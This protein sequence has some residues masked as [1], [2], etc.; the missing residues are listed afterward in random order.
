MKQIY[1][2]DRSR[3]PRL[4]PSKL[5][6]VCHSQ[7]RRRQSCRD[8][9]VSSNVQYLSIPLL[10]P[11]AVLLSYAIICIYFFAFLRPKEPVLNNSHTDSYTLGVFPAAERGTACGVASALSR[12]AGILAPLISGILLSISDNMPLYASVLLFTIASGCMFAVSTF[13]S[14]APSSMSD[15]GDQKLPYERSPI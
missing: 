4:H 6:S 1:H 2:A 5:K 11:F 3:G 8:I 7:H 12:L 9:S 14:L 15:L 13:L 10:T